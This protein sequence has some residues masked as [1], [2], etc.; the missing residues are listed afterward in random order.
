MSDA[1]RPDEPG[2]PS[3]E[4]SAGRP[5]AAS[6]EA[7]ALAGLLEKL[8][9]TAEPPAE[10]EPTDVG[11]YQL[12]E[13]F[14]ALRQDIKLQTKSTRS[15]GEQSEAAVAAIREAEQ[16]FRTAFD[17]M[18][19][20]DEERRT[21]AEAARPLAEALAE[22]DEAVERLGREL[23]STRSR[24][25]SEAGE[26]LGHGVWSRLSK[27]PWWKR[28]LPAASAQSELEEICRRE[29][30]QSLAPLVDPLLKG[31]ELMRQRLH[32]ALE[33]AGIVRVRCE[34]ERVDPQIMTVVEAVDAA[35]REPGV[36]IDEI[37]PGHWWGQEVLRAAEV[38]AVRET[39]G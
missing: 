22:L 24:L 6:E 3:G 36:G 1:N 2:S 39:P 25:V 37:R 12:V 27:G 16:Q 34:G 17:R 8:L 31:H 5:H 15:L 20:A 11:L 10:Q 35:D 28:W 9:G 4:P 23:E 18:E 38:R 26:R 14:T 32:H 7:R 21:A 30:E 13:A 19:R 33:K 29:A